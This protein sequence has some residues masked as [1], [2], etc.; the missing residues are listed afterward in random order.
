MGAEKEN[1]QFKWISGNSG[2]GPVF[3]IDYSQRSYAEYLGTDPRQV[4]RYVIDHPFFRDILR[5]Q[6]YQNQRDGKFPKRSNNAIISIPAESALFFQCFYELAVD[7]KYHAAFCSGKDHVSE[8][9]LAQFLH[10]LCQKISLQI[11]GDD[12]EENPYYRHVLYENEVFR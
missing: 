1:R 10:D 4:K 6:F 5:G 9:I 3:P 12:K 11:E 7:K 8:Q 2:N